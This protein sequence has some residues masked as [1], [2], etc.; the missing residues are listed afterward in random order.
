MATTSS[1]TCQG[2]TFTIPVGVTSN[3]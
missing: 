1:T 3:S 2:A